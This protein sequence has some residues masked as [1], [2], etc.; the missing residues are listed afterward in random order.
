MHQFPPDYW[1]WESS[2]DS[3]WMGDHRGFSPREV[4]FP[5]NTGWVRSNQASRYLKV[6]YIYK[7]MEQQEL[8]GTEYVC[9]WYIS[10]IVAHLLVGIYQLHLTLT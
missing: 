6:A 8:R 2:G 5:G 7:C 3:T 4:G 10:K 9:R 1:K